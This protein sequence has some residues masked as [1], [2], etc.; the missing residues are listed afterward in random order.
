MSH[1][2]YIIQIQSNGDNMVNPTIV[3]TD[4]GFEV[5]VREQ[6]IFGPCSEVECERFVLNLVWGAR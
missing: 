1:P 2:A 6:R 5:R 4:N 3:S